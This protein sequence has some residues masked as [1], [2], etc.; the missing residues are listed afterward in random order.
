MKIHYSLTDLK[1]LDCLG[2]SK[3]N[4]WLLSKYSVINLSVI[5][6]D[7]LHGCP[8]KHTMGLQFCLVTTCTEYLLSFLVG[9]VEF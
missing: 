4:A 1:I 5:Y 6:N 7:F 8:N 9:D 3:G 2:D